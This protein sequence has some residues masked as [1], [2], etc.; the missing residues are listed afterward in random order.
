MMS[1]EKYTI[2]RDMDPELV[3]AQFTT[4]NPEEADELLKMA[5]VRRPMVQDVPWW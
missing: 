2:V 4:D 5:H 3:D 1:Q